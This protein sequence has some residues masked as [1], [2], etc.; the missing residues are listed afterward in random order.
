MKPPRSSR[1]LALLVAAILPAAAPGVRAQ[2]TPAAGKFSVP[3]VAPSAAGQVRERDA[4]D[5]WWNG[6]GIAGDLFGVRDTLGDRGLTFGGQWRSIFLG[7]V[8]GEG[9]PG[10][11]FA[12]D[13]TFFTKLGFAKLLR[14]PGLE[15]LE[16][17][18]E[19]R[20]R[21]PGPLANAN[22][23]VDASRLFNPSRFAG[24]VG[25]RL[26][27]FG[28][29]YTTPE[30]FGIEDFATLRA[31]WLRP[32][33]EFI[34]NPLGGLFADNAIGSQEGLGGN[35]PFGT[36]FSTWGG[37]LKIEPAGWYYAKVGLFMTYPEA[38]S[39]GN[40]GVWFRGNGADPSQNGLL[41]MGETGVT[42]DLGAAKLPGR[43]V[44]GYYY[45]QDGV[46]EALNRYGVYFQADQ[47]LY[48]E[49]SASSDEPSKQG[50]RSFTLF[51][52]APAYNNNY[53]FYFQGGLVYEGLIPSRDRDQLMAALAF[54]KYSADRQPGRDTTTL[55]EAGYRVRV[56]GWA[57]VQPFAQYI[58]RPDG[59]PDVANAAVLGA[60]IGVE[61]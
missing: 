33:R 47:M 5:A 58:A 19:G 8:A 25:W 44:F 12:Q 22:K 30:F 36:S 27:S 51:S 61:F 49:P 10:G 50:L 9:G 40:R 6:K 42:P 1:P 28:L 43:Y 45:Y 31:G 46:S 56:N 20:W 35:I 39:P 55:L 17:F 18:G 59:T 48:R 37:T 16:A 29:S 38:T 54:G 14:W 41:F 23:F 32:Q 3:A 4:L 26:S 7:V 60:Y 57:F 11:A 2:D 34:E 15:G 21:D 53:P 24:G 52:V 13:L